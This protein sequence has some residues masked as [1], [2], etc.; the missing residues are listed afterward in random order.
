MDFLV[1][2]WC[3]RRTRKSIVRIN[4]QTVD[5][6]RC[7]QQNRRS[8]G[9]NRFYAIGYTASVYGCRETGERGFVWRKVAVRSSQSICSLPPAA[10]CCFSQSVNSSSTA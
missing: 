8:S 4:Q 10:S 6:F 9:V 7:Q 3:I 2:Q 5:G 1:R